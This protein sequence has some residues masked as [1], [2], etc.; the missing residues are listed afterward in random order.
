VQAHTPPLFQHVLT[1]TGFAHVCGLDPITAA[2]GVLSM[3]ALGKAVAL[4]SDTSIRID[5]DLP[6]VHTGRIKISC[7]LDLM[8]VNGIVDWTHLVPASVTS[9]AYVHASKLASRAGSV[10]SRRA[11]EA[12]FLHIIEHHVRPLLRPSCRALALLSKKDSLSASFAA[13]SVRPPSRYSPAFLFDALQLLALPVPRLDEPIRWSAVVPRHLRHL[14]YEAERAVAAYL[15]G[16]S[17]FHKNARGY[18][19]VAQIM[20][21]ESN[22]SRKWEVPGGLSLAVLT[23]ALYS[24][25]VRV[26]VMN[27]VESYAF[28]ARVPDF[29][30]CHA[31]SLAAA[32]AASHSEACS[33]AAAQLKD[34]ASVGV[35]LFLNGWDSLLRRNNCKQVERGV[36][37]G[38]NVSASLVDGRPA[39]TSVPCPAVVEHLQ[40]WHDL[41]APAAAA[42]SGAGVATCSGDASCG[43][44]GSAGGVTTAASAGSSDGGAT[45]AAAAP[46]RGGGDGAGAGGTAAE[47]TVDR[48]GFL[49]TPTWAAATS[50]VTLQSLLRT[51]GIDVFPVAFLPLALGGHIVDLQR[52]R[53]A[54][55]MPTAK[56][57]SRCHAAVVQGYV[58]LGLGRGSDGEY[59]TAP[60]LSEQVHVLRHVVPAESVPAPGAP[61]LSCPSLLAAWTRKINAVERDCKRSLADGM[62]YRV[63]QFFWDAPGS[64]PAQQIESGLQYVLANVRVR[65]VE[66]VVGVVRLVANAHF[67][68]GKAAL[69]VLAR[70]GSDKQQHLVCVQAAAEVSAFLSHHSSGRGIL[71]AR[72]IL[73]PAGA[74]LRG[75]PILGACAD[76]TIVSEA[77]GDA[78]MGASVLDS[79]AAAA[80]LAAGAL[81][82]GPHVPLGGL[83]W[84][85]GMDGYLG[86]AAGAGAGSAVTAA[87]RVVRNRALRAVRFRQPRALPVCRTCMAPFVDA[88]SLHAHLL[89]QPTHSVSN[90]GIDASSHLD[91]ASPEYRASF[92]ASLEKWER[93]APAQHAAFLH[94]VRDGR[95]TL[96][97]GAA[98]TGK[99]WTGECCSDCCSPFTPSFPPPLCASILQVARLLWH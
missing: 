1:C 92:R 28:K 76:S 66:P 94:A 15:W 87:P 83:A 17:P 6:A 38:F 8:M 10:E 37:I 91:T 3:D 31:P 23:M 43:S 51:K 27:F 57:P 35:A 5:A 30:L 77:T 62:P 79:P 55:I 42:S 54:V 4:A 74:M 19:N 70:T 7:D 32:V 80:A 47:S 18:G 89:E 81:V 58:P 24:A 72:G 2:S 60:K 73:F 16:S 53:G 61:V 75:L 99:S 65:Q 40:G 67:A 44:A 39:C 46:G 69:A 9:A 84:G 13:A 12:A 21:D 14:W 71:W 93:D 41:A 45:S 90:G 22:V 98:G 20:C 59:C 49:E 82:P 56:P 85:V 34:V 68:L 96:L 52:A 95:N 26:P 25:V 64:S 78:G 48:H 63:E 33:D 97:L 50:A 11:S 86:C 88:A 29:Q 36:G